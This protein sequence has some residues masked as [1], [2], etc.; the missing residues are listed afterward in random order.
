MA[1]CI[2]KETRLKKAV[3][4]NKSGVRIYE[5]WL[6][7]EACDDLQSSVISRTLKA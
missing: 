5:D 1:G 2:G 6:N 3:T 7:V 4:H